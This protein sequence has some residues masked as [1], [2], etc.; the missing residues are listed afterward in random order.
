MIGNYLLKGLL[1]GL[2]FGVPAGA[3]GALTIQRS[4][5]QGFLAGL[6]TGLGSS[7]VDVL[8]A[9][10]GVF[11]VT[12]ISDFL[13]AHQTPI[14]LLGGLLIVSLGV[15]IFR[16]EGRAAERAEQETNLTVLFGSSF[17]IAIANPSTILSFFVA[18]ATFGIGAQSTPDQG[19]CLIVGILLGTGAWW[20]VLS[21]ITSLF[22][23]RI[24]E[25]I[26]A[27]L[28]RILGG[29]MILFGLVMIIRPFL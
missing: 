21:G 3:I 4:L 14:G 26:Y 18:F 1:V 23:E 28:N 5:S 22:R 29:L 25:R 6:F 2:V 7:A 12:V 17:L 13:L 15:I 11:G 20:C 24:T 19:L 9:C 27:I 10:V 8:Y 16:K